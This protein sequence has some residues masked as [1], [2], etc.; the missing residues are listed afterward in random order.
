[1]SLV[2]IIWGLEFYCK[3]QTKRT[4][5]HSVLKKGKHFVFLILHKVETTG[6]R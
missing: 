3:K 1:M 5:I 6:S 2:G 4:S